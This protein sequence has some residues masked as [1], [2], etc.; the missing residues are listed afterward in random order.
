MF[1]KNRNISSKIKRSKVTDYAALTI[2]YYINVHYLVPLAP[3]L[4]IP[5]PPWP[6][7]ITDGIASIK[8]DRPI[9]K[10]IVINVVI[11]N[12]HISLSLFLLQM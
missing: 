9:T 12:V 1:L 10:A 7:G 2:Q 8:S 6:L 3:Q 11:N 4:I 5:V